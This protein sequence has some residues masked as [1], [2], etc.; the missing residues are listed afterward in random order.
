MHKTK[1]W[2]IIYQ[3]VNSG[4]LWMVKLQVI[5]SFNLYC[6]PSCDPSFLYSMTVYNFLCKKSLEKKQLKNFFKSQFLMPGWRGKQ[7]PWSPLCVP[8]WSLRVTRLLGKFWARGPRTSHPGRE[9]AVPVSWAGRP[10]H[11]AW[12][13]QSH[14]LRDL[15]SANRTK[16]PKCGGSHWTVWP[17]APEP[18][19]LSCTLGNMLGEGKVRLGHRE[20]LGS[21]STYWWNR[22]LCCGHM[23]R[24]CRIASRLVSMS[25]PPTSTVPDVGGNR[26]VTM[27]LPKAEISG[28]EPG[29]W[30]TLGQQPPPQ[31]QRG[32]SV[33]LP[34]PLS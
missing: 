27:D 23:P 15:L 31:G 3:S 24:L 4:F 25:F 17:L 32:F 16:D 12:E 10:Q 28:R 5:F 18:A 22:M 34:M 7:E 29:L 21:C 9:K 19:S 33:I 14:V 1:L 6:L 11:W 2:K 13:K 30:N 26:P 8:S 20:G